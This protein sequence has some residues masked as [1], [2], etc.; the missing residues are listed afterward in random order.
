MGSQRVGHDWVTELTTT[1]G[2]MYIY[3]QIP[4]LYNWNLHNIVNQLYFSKNKQ[5]INSQTKTLRLLSGA[6]ALHDGPPPLLGRPQLCRHSPRTPTGQCAARWL[7]RLGSAP[8]HRLFFW[9]HTLSAWPAPMDFKLSSS[10]TR[11]RVTSL[12]T[13]FWV[14]IKYPRACAPWPSGSQFYCGISTLSPPRLTHLAFLPCLELEH[15]SGHKRHPESFTP[16]APRHSAWS[17]RAW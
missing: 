8:Q 10:F 1:C 12:F 11:F 4:L 13:S 15:A 3:S 9:R 14:W 2:Y 6:Q 7:H 17:Q 16:Q 5:I